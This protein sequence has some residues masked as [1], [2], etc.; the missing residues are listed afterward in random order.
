MPKKRPS[1]EQ[2][3]TLLRQIEVATSQGIIRYRLRAGR[4]GSQTSAAG[5]DTQ[6]GDLYSLK[7][8]KIL[9]SQWRQ[10]YNTV[11]PHSSLGYRPPAPRTFM[12]Q[13]PY[14]DGAPAMQA[15]RSPWHKISGRS[16]AWPVNRVDFEIVTIISRAAIRKMRVAKSACR[17][18]VG[19][20]NGYRIPGVIM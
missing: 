17:Y 13:P 7:E 5:R 12:P 14:L 16:S 15:S 1:P 2:I 20:P 9:I 19:S 8:A 6:R 18:R 10:H 4:L 3:V 11:R